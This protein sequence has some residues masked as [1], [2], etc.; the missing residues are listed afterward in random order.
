NSPDTTTYISSSS[1]S[2]SQHKQN[3]RIWVCTREEPVIYVSG[4]PFV[5][6]EASA[7]TEASGLSTRASNLAS[8]ERRLRADILKEA[9]HQH[10]QPKLE[11]RSSPQHTFF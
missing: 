7:P 5:L 9:A 1:P 10:I 3:T 4:R 8:I 6:R 11:Q 2:P